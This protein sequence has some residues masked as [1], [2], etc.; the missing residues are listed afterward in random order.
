MTIVYVCN[1]ILKLDKAKC[2]YNYFLTF[3]FQTCSLTYNDF[4]FYVF[5]RFFTG[6]SYHSKKNT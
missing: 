5:W 3:F 1:I 2:D 6:S 4:F